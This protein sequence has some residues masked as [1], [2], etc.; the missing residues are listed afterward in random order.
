[1]VSA[2]V[3]DTQVGEGPCPPASH[4]QRLTGAWIS[5]GESDL[6]GASAGAFGQSWCA[7]GNGQRWEMNRVDGDATVRAAGMSVARVGFGWAELTHNDGEPAC[8]MGAWM[9]GP[10]GNL[11]YETQPCIISPPNPGWGDVVPSP[12]GLE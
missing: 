6:A 1:M 11:V 8:T 7:E 5:A 10:T 9:N 4:H 12:P 3:L 2:C